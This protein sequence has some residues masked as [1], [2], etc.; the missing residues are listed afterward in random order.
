[1][2][3]MYY[4]ISLSARAAA[5]VQLVPAIEVKA[6]SSARESAAAGKQIRMAA[7]AAEEDADAWAAPRR[8]Q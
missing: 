4:N 2:L 3:Y 5:A 1:M 8:R 6:Q 7:E